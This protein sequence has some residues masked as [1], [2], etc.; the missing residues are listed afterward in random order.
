ML[1]LNDGRGERVGN[2]L[3]TEQERV[4]E[5]LRTKGETYREIASYMGISYQRFNRLMFV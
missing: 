5:A 1:N 3:F 4:V 2:G